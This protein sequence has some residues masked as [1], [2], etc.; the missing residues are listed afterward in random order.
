MDAPAAVDGRFDEADAAVQAKAED[1][2]R[3]DGGHE[4]V[5]PEIIAG[6]DD[7]E[8]QARLSADHFASDQ[9]NPGCPQGQVQARSDARE[10]GWEDNLGQDGRLADSEVAGYFK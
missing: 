10:D 9:E 1:A 4:Q 2:D 5:G 6:I 8:A 7:E 3:D